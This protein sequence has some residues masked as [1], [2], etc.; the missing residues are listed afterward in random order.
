LSNGKFL[1]RAPAEVVEKERVKL[2]EMST[3]LE[4]LEHQR[5]IIRDLAD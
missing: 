4:E 2:R 5:V 1:D 3:A